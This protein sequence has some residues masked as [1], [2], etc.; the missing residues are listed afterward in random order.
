MIEK[1]INNYGDFHDAIV[2]NVEHKTNIDLSNSEFKVGI[3]EV[4]L[5]MY[6]WYRPIYE[7]HLIKIT[8]TEI[9]E[10]RY[11]KFDASIIE[12]FIEKQNNFYIIDFDPIMTS[13]REGS[14]TKQNSESMLSIKFKDLVYEIIG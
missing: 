4:I 6:C 14:I 8:F 12:S 5:V 9:E 2:L 10:F 13:N 1:L 11:I 7:K 3:Q